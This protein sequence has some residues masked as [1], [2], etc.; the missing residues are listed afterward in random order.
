ESAREAN[1]LALPARELHATLADIGIIPPWQLHDHRVEPG[2]LRRLDHR[3][4]IGMAEA[5]DIVA[6]APGEKLDVLRQIANMP[7]AIGRVPDRDVGAVEPDIAA[8][9]SPSARDA[10]CQGGLAGGR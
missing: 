4:G 7:A 8:C 5:R 1:A 2:E 10:P 6:D 3:F 9:G